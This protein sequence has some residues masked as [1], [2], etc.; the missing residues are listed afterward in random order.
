MSPIKELLLI[1]FLSLI[2]GLIIAHFFLDD[3][4]NMLNELLK[5]IFGKFIEKML[6]GMYLPI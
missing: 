1:I 4:I 3:I 6:F 2:L 5:F